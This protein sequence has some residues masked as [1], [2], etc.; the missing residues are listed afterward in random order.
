MSIMPGSVVP[1]PDH[2]RRG[3]EECRL[4]SPALKSTHAGTNYDL[5]QQ[6]RHQGN[7]YQCTFAYQNKPNWTP[8]AVPSLWG[9]L[10]AQ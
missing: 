6:G 3:V 2:P 5:I 7:L 8:A 10:P 1:S 4:G 9:E